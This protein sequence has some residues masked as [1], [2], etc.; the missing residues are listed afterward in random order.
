[1]VVVRGELGQVG[2]CRKEYSSMMGVEL[3]AGEE[4][5][6]EAVIEG[7]REDLSTI[8]LVGEKLAS[9]RTGSQD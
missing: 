7:E 1:M 5:A 3:R 2:T 9:D 4:V 8:I 6:E